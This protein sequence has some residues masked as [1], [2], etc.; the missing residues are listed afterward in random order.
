[1]RDGD[2]LH[3]MAEGKVKLNFKKWSS[4]RE[5]EREREREFFEKIFTNL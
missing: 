4:M 1:M 3:F 2:G 5:R